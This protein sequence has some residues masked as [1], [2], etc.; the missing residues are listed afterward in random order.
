MEP[1]G[2]SADSRSMRSIWKGSITFGLVTIPVALYGATKREE[3]KFRLLRKRDLSPINYRRVASADG[4]E[5]PWEEIVKGYEYKKGKFVVLNENDFKRVDIEAAG[6]NIGIRD[7]VAI[8]DINPIFFYKPYYLEPQ[9]GGAGAYA[10][11]RNVL[12]KENKVG[13]AKVVIRSREHLAAVKPNGRLLV[14]ELMHFADELVPA[15][16]LKVPAEKGI[17]KREEQMA[18]TL[19]EQM[20]AKWDPERYKDTYKSAVMKIIER[21]VEAG[22]KELPTAKPAKP[23]ATNVIDLVAVL[24]KSLEES[25]KSAGHA[26]PGKAKKKATAKRKTAQRKAA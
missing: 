12:A 21:K 5:V 17:G 11:L 25:G 7:F 18:S 16:G 13:I 19:V 23:A 4:K 8:D 10:L 2:N 20:T 3:L 6:E 9:R 15:E 22:G 1:R 26:K 24:Q 14:L